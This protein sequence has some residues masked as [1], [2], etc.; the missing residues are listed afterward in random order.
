MGYKK[1]KKLSKEE[2]KSQVGSYRK[3]NPEKELKEARAKADKARAAAAK[4][5]KSSK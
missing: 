2:V 4:Q 1:V 3:V 5:E